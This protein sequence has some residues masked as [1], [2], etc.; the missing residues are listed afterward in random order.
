VPDFAHERPLTFPAVKDV[1]GDYYRRLHEV[2]TTHWWHLGMRRIEAALLGDRLRV[3]SQSLL[4]A[5]CGTGGFLAW[6][7]EVGAFDRLCGADVSSEAIGLARKV[8]PQ[9][10]LRVA[11]LQVLPFEEAAFDV[12]VLNDVL[13]HVH[14]DD[15]EPGLRELRR[16]LRPRGVLLLRTNGAR[17]ARRERA[18]WR[19]YDPNTLE[20]DLA[21]GGFRVLR[22]TYANAALS[23]FSAACGQKPRAP[24]CGEDGLPAADG[25][26][27]EAVGSRLLAL[28]ARFLRKQGRRLPYG[29]S[30]LALAAPGADA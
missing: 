20:T 17:Q 23:L 29:H 6:A 16:V 30:L 27:K 3:S 25:A 9:A 4:D 5:G 1:P 26:V 15:V 7:A 22:M 28:E 21:R 8:V 13:Q 12:A 24:T 14:E 19:V 18:D 2:D 10:D 11:P